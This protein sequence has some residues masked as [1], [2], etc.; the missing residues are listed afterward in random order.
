MQEFTGLHLYGPLGTFCLALIGAVIW[1]VKTW[2]ADMA[3]LS[4]EAAV[5]L[6]AKSDELAKEQEAHQRTRDAHMAELRN[7]MKMADS[8]DEMRIQLVR[9]SSDRNAA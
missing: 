8:I 4:A 7:M 2:R 1:L 5:A 6:K 3:R 9:S